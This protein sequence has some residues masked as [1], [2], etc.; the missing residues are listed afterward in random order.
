MTQRVRVRRDRPS[1]V[2]WA[3]AIAVAMLF[4]YLA[5]L[6]VPARESENEPASARVTREIVLEPIEAAFVS[7]CAYSDALNARVAAAEL[8]LRGAAGYVY[9]R[10]GEWQVLGAAYADFASARLQAEALCAREGLPASAFSLFAGGATLR[11]TAP[12]RIVD[13]IVNADRALRAQLSQLGETADRLDRGK[14][15]ASQARTLAAVAR[16]ELIAAK[17]A[18]EDARENALCSAL[19]EQLACAIRELDA[20]RTVDSAALSGCLRLC[21]VQGEIGLIELLNAAIAG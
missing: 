16:S 12:E 14:I 18:L 4:V 13:A 11:V 7:I 1:A 8:S 19:S 21:Q 2:T 17:D 6:S 20:I 5:T 3:F 10:G 9:A 15:G